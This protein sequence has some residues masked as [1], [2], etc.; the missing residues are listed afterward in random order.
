MT[1]AAGHR[2]VMLEQAIDALAPVAGGV[3]V[4][5]TFGRGGH[6]AAL[7]AALDD[8][9]TVWLIDRDPEAIAL[10]HTL[11][12]SDSRCHIVKASFA[13]LGAH[14]REA[15]LV[16]QVAGIL[17]D[18]GVSSPQLDDPQRGFSFMRSGPLDMRMDNAQGETAAQWLARVDEVA[19]VRVLRDY[20]EERFAR[21]IARA[22]CQARDAGNLPETTT[23]LA[24][25]IAA[26]VPRSEPGKHPATRSFQAIRIHLNDE[27][28]ALDS[29]LSDVCDLLSPAGR[30]VVI[31]FHSLE[32]RR[33]KRFINRHSQVGALPP[34]AGQVPPEKQPRLRR[35]G[36]ACRASADE[37]ALNPRARSA[38]LRIAERL[39]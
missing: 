26:A 5:G 11:Y 15:G 16:G 39:P 19:L 8:D 37:V 18:L 30:L 20:G 14:L 4:D 38:T 29:V 6:A 3:Y 10:A 28:G 1:E 17:L 22:L 7:L 32:D 13:E 2:P 35:I 34:G 27:L 9:A 31:S 23:D 33:V 24:A 12:G 36:R 25:L 21:R